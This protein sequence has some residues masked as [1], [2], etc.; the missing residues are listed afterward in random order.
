MKNKLFLFTMFI[1]S[2]LILQ[3]ACS[4]DDLPPPEEVKK[5][6]ENPDNPDGK[7]DPAQPTIAYVDYLTP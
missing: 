3:T 7:V 4:K 2:V 6:E 1:F 5:E